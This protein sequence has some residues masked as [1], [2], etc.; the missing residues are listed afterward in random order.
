MRPGV[1][2]PVAAAAMSAEQLAEIKRLQSLGYA[3]GSQPVSTFTGTTIN[4]PDFAAPNL[5]FY[6][7]GHAPGATLID[8][9][10]H[11]LHTWQFSYAQ[12]ISA[13]I[14][15]E[16]PFLADNKRTTDCWRRARLLPD[17]GVLAI[18]EGHGLVRLDRESQLVWSYAGAC[19]HDLD[20]A[21]DGSIYILT[22]EARVLPR[23]HPRKPVLLD[24]I[25]HLSPDG[26]ELAKIDVMEAFA[27]S[28]YAS[29]LGLL[30]EA[31]DIF[32]TNTLELL[33]GSLAHESPAFKEG[34]FLISIREIGVVAIIDPQVK[35]V[36]WALSGMWQAQHQPT[37]LENGNLLI[38]D[39]QGHF[40]QSKV[41]ELD[42]LT[43]Q[44]VWEFSNSSEAPFYS[45]TCGSSQRLE[46]GNTLITESDNGRAFEISAAGDIVWEFRNPQ[47]TGT[48]NQYIAAILEMVAL[49]QDQKM[50]WLSVND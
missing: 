42:P 34:N 3:G 6:L 17:G 31:G 19:H 33:D 9:A 26:I 32:H 28:I 11:V 41:V 45:E 43:Q 7:S 4:Q 39:N 8:P 49:P 16:K 47:R 1:G 35:Q 13:N 22:R 37:L 15:G 12:C 40:G 21:A 30:G 24:F 46:N 18:F 44:I 14:N 48:E 10:G 2:G 20:L 25:T 27:N 23:F 38:F 5:R 29:Y 50:A 36:V